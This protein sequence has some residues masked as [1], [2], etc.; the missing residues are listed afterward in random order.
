MKVL[1][2]V[3]I[4][5]VALGLVLGAANW[6]LWGHE[7]P[8]SGFKTAPLQRGS[9]V[10]TISATGTIEPEEVIDVGSQVGGLIIAF[11]TDEQGKPIDY[12]STVKAGTVLAKIDESL[13]QSDVAQAQAQLDQA[14]AGQAYAEANLQQLQAKL[15][16]AQRDWERAQKIGPS[17]ALSQADYDSYKSAY[18]VAKAN[19]AVGQASIV[20]AKSAV[21]AAQ[22]TFDKA[23]RNLGYCIIKSPVQGVIIDRRVNIGQTVVSSLSAPSLFLIAKDL[24]QMEIWVAVNEADIGQ[25]RVGQPV[26]FT[27]DAF[28]GKRFKGQV[29]KIRLNATMTQNVVTYTVVVST[30]NSSGQLLPY[31]TANVQFEIARHENVLT[32]PNAALRWTPTEDQIEPSQRDKAPTKATRGHSGTLWMAEGQFV[33]PV[34]VQVGLTDGIK[35]EVT[36]EGLGEGTAVVI[37]EQVAGTVDASDTNNP[38]GPPK[39]WQRKKK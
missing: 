39:W 27:V 25:I 16:Q 17:D 30:D 10:S 22:A 18:E 21:E 2:R 38:F 11:G 31:L 1:L 8:A 35:T 23:Q 4:V 32:V 12:G 24:K 28:G 29:S 13:Y 26:T 14:K 9:I 37:G 20:Q 33:R 6:L 15:N 3:V 7:A 36:G 5:V 34:P 19:V